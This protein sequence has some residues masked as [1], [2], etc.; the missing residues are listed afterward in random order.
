MLT[1]TEN[2]LIHQ[3]YAFSLSN[4]NNDFAH[5]LF[6]FGGGCINVVIP[7]F[8]SYEIYF[9]SLF[10]IFWCNFVSNS[11]TQVYF[12]KTSNYA[13]TILV[14]KVFYLQTFSAIMDVCGTSFTAVLFHYTFSPFISTSGLFDFCLFDELFYTSILLFFIYCRKLTANVFHKI[15]WLFVSILLH[16]STRAHIMY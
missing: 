15:L 7:T 1:L 6:F 12:L 2:F 10:S 9:H 3:N 14:I 11:S 4:E 8:E 13:N 16:T 5:E